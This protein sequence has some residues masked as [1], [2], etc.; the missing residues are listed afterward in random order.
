MAA[1]LEPPPD[2]QSGHHDHRVFEPSMDEHLALLELMEHSFN[3]TFPS[4]SSSV[5]FTD[6][7][8][9]FAHTSHLP[10]LLL[11]APLDI[12]NT[13]EHRINTAVSV[14]IYPNVRVSDV[15]K[16][17]IAVKEW[18]GTKFFSDYIKDGIEYNS[19]NSDKAIMLFESP[20]SSA[21]NTSF[22][23]GG[24]YFQRGRYTRFRSR[25][26]HH[27]ISRLQLL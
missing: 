1:T 11:P 8:S 7:I 27:L 22:H 6:L 19:N 15:P 24:T 12:A 26:D 4:D 18:D 21:V 3:G 5:A 23:N 2:A 14:S 13:E 9:K 20:S 16:L 17:D 10:P 25:V